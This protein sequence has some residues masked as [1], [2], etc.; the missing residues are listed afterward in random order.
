M[1][2]NKLNQPLSYNKVLK[3]GTT[4][5][6]FETAFDS[7]ADAYHFLA[8]RGTNLQS[9]VDLM[10]KA[11]ARALS[12][13]EVNQLHWYATRYLVE[14]ASRTNYAPVV[15]MLTAAREAGKRFPLLRFKTRSNRNLFL[16]LVLS[17]K[18]E[19]TVYVTEGRGHN[20]TVFGRLEKNGN[21]AVFGGR[22]LPVDVAV[23][24]YRLAYDPAA[25]AKQH[26]VQT[27]TCCFCGR[28]LS[29]KESVAAGYGPDCAD[30]HGLP[31]GHIITNQAETL[32]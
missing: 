22:N 3:C 24:M 6:E 17:G 4:T 8:A 2:E 18:N 31:W 9:E 25:A 7:L 19:G 30:A 5:S 28:A 16:K 15:Q 32:L 10:A 23:I 14:E 1:N 26:G 27:G 11:R 29:T 12:D 21:I 13:Y 20:A